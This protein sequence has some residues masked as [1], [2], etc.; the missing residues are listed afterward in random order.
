[1]FHH[2]TN[3]LSTSHCR[4]FTLLLLSSLTA[5]LPSA[6]TSAKHTYVYQTASHW[7]DFRFFQSWKLY[8][9]LNRNDGN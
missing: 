4:H 8:Q 9:E 5:V 7:L 3:F 1:M 6:Q 2:Y